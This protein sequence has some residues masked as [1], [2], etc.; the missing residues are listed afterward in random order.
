[1]KAAK[2]LYPHIAA[3]MQ[4][5]ID[6]AQQEF[7]ERAEAEAVGYEEED[8]EPPDLDALKELFL[9]AMTSPELRDAFLATLTPEQMDLWRRWQARGDRA[10]VAR[11]DRPAAPPARPQDNGKGNGKPTSPA[12]L[13]ALLEA[14]AASRRKPERTVS[15]WRSIINK[16]VE[17]VGHDDAERLTKQ[18][19]VHWRDAA[20]ADGKRV[21]TVECYLGA[22]RTVIQAALDDAR[23]VRTDNPASKVKVLAEADQTDGVR[24]YTREEASRALAAARQQKAPELRYLPILLFSTPARLSEVAGLRIKDVWEDDAGRMTV[25]ITPTEVRRLKVKKTRSTPLPDWAAEE[26][27]EYVTKRQREAQP[28]DLLFPGVNPPKGSTGYTG[29]NIG[30]RWS[31]VV[32]KKAGI[33]DPN[34]SPAHSTRHLYIDL[35][36]AAG[37]D[38]A[39]IDR[40]TG[41][42]TP[43]LQARYGKG[44]DL[45]TLRRAISRITWPD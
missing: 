43:G 26:I 25:E 7:E 34:I 36:R 32:R 9:S 22:V 12:S 6:N 20:L 37:L 5:L 15:Q 30:K 38:A 8:Y 29:G 35:C 31:T 41:H 2:R 19:L 14:W 23:L 24:P 44:F 17:F 21:G 10:A 42:S 13:Y 3:Q 18:D 11:A 28:D 27:R 1:M 33:I 4:K 16:L 39:L 45:A 40:L